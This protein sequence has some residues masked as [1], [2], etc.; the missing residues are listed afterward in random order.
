MLSVLSALHDRG[1]R[2]A[3]RLV[4]TLTS[5]R[6]GL[7]A[8]IETMARRVEEGYCAEA[9]LLKFRTEAALAKLVATGSGTA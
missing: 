5:N 8:I 3:F 6:E 7:A 9:D 1:M 4:A 2:T